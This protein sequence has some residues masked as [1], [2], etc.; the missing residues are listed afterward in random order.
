[1][2]DKMKRRAPANIKFFSGILKRAIPTKGLRTSEATLKIPI[3]TP[4]SASVDP[5]LQR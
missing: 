3:S 2:E 1:M 4:I 5:D